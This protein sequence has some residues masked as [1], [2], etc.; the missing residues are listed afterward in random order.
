[1][2]FFGDDELQQAPV[3]RDYRLVVY[4]HPLMGDNKEVS[5]LFTLFFFFWFLADR[6]FRITPGCRPKTPI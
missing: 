1:M 2:W 3:W 4:H 6:C 5:N